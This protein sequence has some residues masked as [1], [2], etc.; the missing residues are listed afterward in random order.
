MTTVNLY[1]GLNDKDTKRQEI[2]NLDAKAEISAILFKYFPNGFTLQECQGMYKH[3]DGTVVCENTIKVI[4]FD[5]NMGL[6][7]DAVKELKLKLNQECIA[8]ERI[9]TT[10]NFV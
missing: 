1:I 3:D 4:L 7:S 10:I 6:V 2:T 5:Y 9:E 8:V